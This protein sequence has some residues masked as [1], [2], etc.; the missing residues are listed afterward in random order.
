MTPS[1]IGIDFGGTNVRA[2]KVE[3]NE[4]TQHISR[5][6]SS[7]ETEAVVLQEIFITIDQ[8]FDHNVQGIGIGVP[9]VVDVADGIVYDVANIPS[10]KKVHLKQLMEQRYGVPVHVNN[11]ANCFALGECY[12]GKAKDFQNVVGLIIGTGIG[13]GVIIA[14]KLYNGSNCGAGEFGHIP[15]QCH[16]FEY[17]CSGQR[18]ER[19]YGISGAELFEKAQKDD[20]E[21]LRI[22]DLFGLDLG[23]AIQAVLY[24]LDP[25]IIVLGG[26]VSNAYP[27]FQT[28]MFETLK[29]FKYQH[30]LKR[31]II[32]R[33][34]NPQ[35]AILG[36][37]ALVYDAEL[38]KQEPQR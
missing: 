10:W 15:Y 14:K 2:G 34:Q 23:N 4:L 21:A 13:A 37:A 16:D 11:D 19:D 27:Y 30:A 5:A 36:A 6:I 28:A 35:I 20:R 38:K 29:K 3:N 1:V 24:A 9:S 33:S 7:Q 31:L 26:S 32:E 18:F 12:F 22:F 25:Q 17:Y 8:V